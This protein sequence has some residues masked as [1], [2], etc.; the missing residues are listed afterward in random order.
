MKNISLNREIGKRLRDLRRY[1]GMSRE[2]LAQQLDISTSHIGL[3][4]RGERGLSVSKA[5]KV[6]GMFSVQ[7]NYLLAGQGEASKLD[8]SNLPT[9][10][11]NEHE[12]QLLSDFVKAYSLIDP[13]KRNADIIFE[14]V[15]FIL[16]QYAKTTHSCLQAHDD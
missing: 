6:S 11:F 5:L 8:D 14:G 9:A 15:R 2:M 16:T 13:E 3:I 7:L 10:G 1:H 12:W 4:E